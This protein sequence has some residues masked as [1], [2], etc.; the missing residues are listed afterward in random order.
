[1]NFPA[2]YQKRQTDTILCVLSPNKFNKSLW[3]L[4]SHIVSG[5]KTLYE[6]G[7]TIEFDN[8]TH[9]IFGNLMGISGDNL[10]CH[11]A[12][13]LQA[14]FSNG[15]CCRI[16]PATFEFVKKF[17]YY[18]EKDKQKILDSGHKIPLNR[19]KIKHS[20]DASLGMQRPNAFSGNF[21]DLVPDIDKIQVVDV[22]HDNLQGVVP[23]LTKLL[24]KNMKFDLKKGQQKFE[25]INEII[26]ANYFVHGRL[27]VNEK[28]KCS[29]SGMQKLEFWQ[30]I[31]GKIT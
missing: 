14:S 18:Q 28:L 24:L 30:V 27:S 6:T 31:P 2:Q 4:F 12:Y 17:V 22:F 20:V 5:L 23:S 13:G 21:Y 8:Q 15:Y 19:D 10:F 25:F 26:E 1:M 9:T 3:F 7:I 16:C 11:Y 29:G